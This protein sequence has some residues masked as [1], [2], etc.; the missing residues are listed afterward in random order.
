MATGPI[1]AAPAADLTDLALEDLLQVEVTTAS[2]Y[3]QDAREAP[4]QVQ[5]ITAEEIRQ[6]GWRTLGEALSSLPGFYLSDDGAYQYLGA[7]GFLTPGNY[8]TRFQLL[9]NGQRLNDNILEQAQFGYT[10]PLD[11]SL[12]ERIEVIAGPGSAIYGS[13]AM[14]GVINVIVR[15]PAAV[16]GTTASAGY[17]TDGWKELR[18]STATPVGDSGAQL[19]ASVS[20][21]DK[22]AR[23]LA[24]P[25]AVGALQSDGSASTDGIARGLGAS[26][27]GRAYFAL[28]QSG[29][30]ASAWAM[31]RNLVPSLALFGG[32]FNDRRNTIAD[33]SYGIAASFEHRIDNDL[34]FTG[35]LAL[36]ELAFG[37]DFVYSDGSKARVD[38]TGDWLS[39][40]SRFVYSGL[41][42]HKLV[43]GA[44]MLHDTRVLIRNVEP[45]TGTVL[46]DNHDGGSRVGVYVQDEWVMS[47][48]WRMTAGARF[49]RY[50]IDLAH[51]SPRI[52]LVHAP[53]DA[54]TIKLLA[55][56]AYRVPSAFERNYSDGVYYIANSALKPEVIRTFD[57][58]IERRVS[59]DNKV[60]VSLFYYR[61]HNQIDQTETAAGQFQYQN[62]VLHVARGAEAWWRS[63]RVDTGTLFASLGLNHSHD[64]DGQ[65]PPNSPSWILKLRATHPLA[66]PQWQGALEIDAIGPR[67]LE[68]TTSVSRIGRQWW[69]NAVIN[70]N[71]LARNTRLQLRV[72]NLFDRLVQIPVAEAAAPLYP[73][74]RRTLQVTLSHDF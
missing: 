4:S 28:R 40:E 63:G 21:A 50:S 3:K 8:S 7:R 66:G 69:A 2:K 22:G 5:V 15:D 74:N 51:T 64:E 25:S 23:N 56:E 6:F 19:L 13:N 32:A 31:Q 49:D 44:D 20:Y 18:A 34:E 10:F 61:Y 60:G 9:L 68:D 1:V 70:A 73:Y 62:H 27:L 47:P 52:G 55:G 33:T 11:L 67:S 54:T 36:Q 16:K 30:Q 26:Q 53:N 65:T 72:L 57:A 43:F 24:I 17:T 48:R 35:R 14:F 37:G 12:V 29:F 71:G 42:A 58:I 45:T 38:T 46:L 41:D 59:A 39:G